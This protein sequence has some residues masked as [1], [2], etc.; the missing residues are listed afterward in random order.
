MKGQEKLREPAQGC[1]PVSETFRGE[2][3]GHLVVQE[4]VRD[5]QPGSRDVVHVA[6]KLGAL[7]GSR[8][9]VV[10]V[11]GQRHQSDVAG[12]RNVVVVGGESERS[13]IGLI[14]MQQL[15]GVGFPVR[16]VVG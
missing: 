2:T 6:S 12:V 1:W 15:W 5:V 10:R 13:V 14:E 11:E 4:M 3:A 16:M 9:R 8:V 7:D